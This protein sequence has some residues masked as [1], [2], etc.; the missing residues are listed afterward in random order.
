V[1]SVTHIITDN[2]NNAAA[3]VVRIT[4]SSGF[5]SVTESTTTD[6]FTVVLSQQP[7]SNV[8]VT[9][10]GDSQVAVSPS[11]LTFIPGTTGSGTFNV[12]QTVTVR[13]IDDAVIEPAILHWGTVTATVAS[14]DTFFDGKAVTA[15]NSTVYD[16]DGSRVSVIQSGGSTL[17]NENGVTDTYTLS[18]SHAPTSDVVITATANAQLSLSS[19]TLTFTPADWAP[20]TL[21]I[22]AVND[23]DVEAVTH[24]GLITHSVTSADPLYHNASIATLTVP[25]WDNDVAS[26]DVTHVGGT[27]T[28]VTEGGA[29]DSILIKLNTQPPTGTNV[30]LTLYPPMVFIQPPQIGKS[31]GYFVNDQ[32]GSNQ[33]D[34]IVIDYTESILHYRSTFYSTLAAL[35]APAAIPTPFPTTP[36]AADNIKL[37]KAHWAAS[38]AV[39]DQMDLWFNGG[40]MKAKFPV[41]VEPHTTPPSPLPPINARQA[42]IEAIYA[43]SGGTDLPATKRYTAEGT[44]N[45]KVPPTD[46]FNTDIRDRVRWC[47]YLMTVGAPGLISH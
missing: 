30:T 34:N 33:R 18:L 38:K 43:H 15:V 19:S 21:T 36:S 40:S 13:A 46:T 23:A 44:Y 45:A 6:T 39:V 35:Y 12:A 47:G 2:D 26:V 27:D 29:P 42:I 28:V 17:T 5:T 3:N 32:G 20:K 9:F 31:N 7:T 41:L 11:T 37:Q 8:T 16:N 1:P 14:A 10:T 22:T 24:N 25:V 4:E